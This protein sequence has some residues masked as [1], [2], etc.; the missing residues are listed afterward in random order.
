L[1]ALIRIHH[2]H[3]A[4]GMLRRRHNRLGV[5][6]LAGLAL[7]VTGCENYPWL[8]W[9]GSSESALTGGILSLVNPFSEVLV[10]DRTFTNGTA[11]TTATYAVDDLNRIPLGIDFNSDGKIDPVVCY[12]EDQAVIQILLSTGGTGV[13]DPISLTLDSKYD[14]VNLADVAVADI[15][16]DGYLDIVAAAEDAVWYFRHPPSGDPTDLR[17]WGALDPNDTLRERIDASYDQ[18]DDDEL[19][20]IIDQAIDVTVALTDYVI[21]VEQLYTNIEAA[22]FDGDGDF[23]VAASRSFIINLEP[24]VQGLVEAIQIVDGD[25]MVLV[26]PGFALDGNNWT[27]LSIGRHERQLRLDRDGATGLLVHDMD[28]DGQLDVVSSARLDNNAQV[29]WFRNPGGVLTTAN[30][31]TQ[32]RVGSVRDSWALDLGDVTGDGWPDLIATG[33]EQMQTML[34]VHP[35]VAF[36]DGRYEYDWESHVITNFRSYAPRDAKLLDVDNDGVLE[37]VLSGTEGAIRYFEAPAD[38]TQEWSGAS[39][40][41]FEDGG[42]VGLLGYGDLDGDD[43][44]DLVATVDNTEDNFCRTVWIRNDLAR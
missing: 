8:P 44:L 2:L 41:T 16:G 11:V 9:L 17:D 31:W 36:P 32:Y 42:T 7:A 43:D 21:T 25:V 13:V 23:D 5:S 19:T 4:A 22:D 3:G 37:L 30:P 24:R 12:G 40:I 1:D 20:E 35:G 28:D 39:V 38:A 26:N 10:Q 27:Q 33:G 34:F 14:M 6:L 29:A 15:D 18:I